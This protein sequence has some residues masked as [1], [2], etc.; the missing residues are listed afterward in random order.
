M[1]SSKVTQ[2]ETKMRYSTACRQLGGEYGQL[3]PLAQKNQSVKTKLEEITPSHIKRDRDH[4]P[5]LQG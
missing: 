5:H 4:T 1:N 3:C 2:D